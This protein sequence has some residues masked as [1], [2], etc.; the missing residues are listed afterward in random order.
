M[1]KLILI[2]LMVLAIT[3]TSVS[4]F[5][6]DISNDKVIAYYFY[7]KVRCYTCN[8][9]E[10][11]TKEAI[12]NNFKNALV[13]GKLEFKAVNIEERGNEHFVNDYKLYTRSVIL[14]L[15]KGNKEIKSKNLEK[16]W[17]LSRNKQ[18][19]IDYVSEEINNLLKELQ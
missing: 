11:L 5:A 13:S 2:L 14:S 17:K 12:E 6:Q 16:I 8:M 15:V 19:F 10:K 1:K 9:M 18:K 7:G 3:S 4:V